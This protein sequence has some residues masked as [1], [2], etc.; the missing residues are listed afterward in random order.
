MSPFIITLL[1]MALGVAFGAIVMWVYMDS[2]VEFW[3]GRFTMERR[4]KENMMK[5]SAELLEKQLSVFHDLQ[6]AFGTKKNGTTR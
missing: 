1:I 5:Q 2:R 4:L 3:Q 6:G